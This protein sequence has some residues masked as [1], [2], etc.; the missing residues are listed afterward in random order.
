MLTFKLNILWIV[1]QIKSEFL[2]KLEVKEFFKT[3]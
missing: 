1:T 3:N 2:V